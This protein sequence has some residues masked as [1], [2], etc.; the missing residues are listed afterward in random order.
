MY[1]E[2]KRNPKTL[3]NKGF[4][5]KW[6]LL[7][8]N[9]CRGFGGYIVDYAVNALDLVYYAAGGGVKHLIRDARPVCRHKVAGCYGAESHG[10]V[11]S[12]EIAHNADR[13]HICKH[14]EILT[15]FWQ[16]SRG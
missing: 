7:P 14:R 2:Q 10:V 16:F 12:S 6:R 8:L 15:D 13:A 4:S 9:S 11:V 1:P 5:G 3:E